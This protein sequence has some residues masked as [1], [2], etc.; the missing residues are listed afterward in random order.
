MYIEFNIA[1]N[2]KHFFATTER[3][4][5]NSIEADKVYKVLLDKFPESEGYS[6]KASLHPQ[7]SY[8]IDLSKDI[9][10]E[11]DDILTNL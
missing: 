10:F 3:S 4:C 8:G 2:G 9:A 1:L 7:R 5:T 11:V 6:I